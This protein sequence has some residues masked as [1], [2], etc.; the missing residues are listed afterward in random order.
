MTRT[1]ISNKNPTGTGI[2]PKFQMGNGIGTPPLQDP[3]N[4]VFFVE[5]SLF[6]RLFFT[7]LNKLPAYLQNASPQSC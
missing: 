3:L 1:G 4:T 5:F 7:I 2:S 6:S